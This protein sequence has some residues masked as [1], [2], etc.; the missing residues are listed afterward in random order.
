M[1]FMLKPIVR[2]S[3]TIAAC[4]VALSGCTVGPDFLRP[5]PPQTETYLP[6]S[7]PAEFVAA[8]IPGGEAQA[9]VRSLDIPGQWWQVF[10]SRPLN[11]LIEQALVANPDIQAA[12][13]ALRIA[14]AN[15]R[16][17][18]GTLFP[19]VGLN[20]GAS[21]NQNPASLQSPTADNAQNYSL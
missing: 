13:A 4:C 17:T 21:Q 3:G 9:I 19:T 11:G 1:I 18:R 14:Q 10:Q 20:A 16:A 12:E 7:P 2:L 6:E 15:A 8:D 5:K